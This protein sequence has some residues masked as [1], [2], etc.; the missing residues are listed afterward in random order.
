MRAAERPGIDD[1]ARVRR[2]IRALV[3]RFSV[4]E[5]ADVACCGMT[6]AQAAA[7]EVL[8]CEG[9]MRLGDLGRRLGI[10]PS[11]LTRN[12]ERL[13][14][15]G[16]ARRLPDPDDARSARAELTDRGRAAGASL[17][18]QEQAFAATILEG[19]PP[20]VRGRIAEDLDA[21]LGAVREAT[22]SCCPGAFEHLMEEIA[23][24]G[25]VE[26]SGA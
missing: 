23:A 2:A 26:R 17:E 9:P 6:V 20:G 18:R 3:R 10:A 16:L 21:L 14:E 22:S 8:A 11:T 1:A 5:R 25:A 19:L 7:V 12:L 4:S 13:E 15:R 24:P